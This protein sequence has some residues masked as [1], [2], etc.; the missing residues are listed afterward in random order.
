MRVFYTL[1]FLLLVSASE[2]Q[3]PLQAS[4]DS[5][6]LSC[7]DK[8]P[9]YAVA[10]IKE[11]KIEYLKG[12][13]MANLEYN[14]PISPETVFHLASVSKQFTA[15]GIYLLLSA[16]KLQLEEPVKKYL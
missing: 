4:I 11:G 5:L 1:F 8:T 15:Y 16:G 2:A 6:F 7:T 13:G 9:G 3:S 14:T 12:Y 10:V